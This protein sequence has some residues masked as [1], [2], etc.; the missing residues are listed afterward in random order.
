VHYA[1][2]LQRQRAYTSAGDGRKMLLVRVLAYGHW[3]VTNAPR[4]QAR[5]CTTSAHKGAISTSMSSVTE[6]VDAYGH[7]PEVG[8]WSA[9]LWCLIIVSSVEQDLH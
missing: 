1:E 7:I 4:D 3:S 9:L 5:S 2:A 8:S 6:A